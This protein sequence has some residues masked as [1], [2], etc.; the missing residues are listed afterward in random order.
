MHKRQPKLFVGKLYDKSLDK[1]TK[2]WFLVEKKVL[3]F[4]RAIRWFETRTAFPVSTDPLHEGTIMCP[5]GTVF[6]YIY[7]YNFFYV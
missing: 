7:K 6:T 3:F 2:T 1:R 5:R 4:A